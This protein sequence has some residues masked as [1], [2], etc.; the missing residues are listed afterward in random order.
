M[1]H[2]PSA[3]PWQGHLFFIS[4]YFCR[5]FTSTVSFAECS[6]W[7]SYICD[8]LLPGD[9]STISVTSMLF[10]HPVDAVASSI[11]ETS[12]PLTKDF[13]RRPE[14]VVSVLYE[15]PDKT[16]RCSVKTECLHVDLL[17]P[18]S[19]ALLDRDRERERESGNKGKEGV[20]IM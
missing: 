14:V 5:T 11:Y 18:R 10:L 7:L 16:L 20:C 13:A 6:I 19:C 9:G 17:N 3:V 8:L 4:I 2:T 12:V 1:I 15:R